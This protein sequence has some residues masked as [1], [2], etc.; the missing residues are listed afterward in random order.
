MHIVL[1]GGT[2]FVG[3]ALL[4]LL[5]EKGHTST[6]LTRNKSQHREINLI[7]GTRLEQ[8]N[9]YLPDDLC[10]HLE[11]ADA[12]INLVG[13]LNESGRNGAGFH[14]AHVQLVDEMISACEK[15]GIQ[16]I[17]HMSALNAGA[18]ESHYLESKGLAERRIARA[19]ESRDLHFTIFQPSVIFGKNDDFFNRF[20]A[21]LRVLPVMPLARPS[22]RMQPVFVGDVAA[23]FAL[24]LEDPGTH[25]KTFALCGPKTYTLK[26][27]VEFTAKT[28]NLQRKIIPLPDWLA[29]LQALVMDFVPGKP[30]SSDNYRSLKTDSTSKLNGLGYFKITPTSIETQVFQ[31]LG[32]GTHQDLLSRLRAGSRFR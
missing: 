21:L 14:R 18:G 13:I 5:A 27:L 4:P 32:R 31:Y 17:L 16:R 12:V 2:G 3:R 7:P 22:A 24:A 9:V 1:L 28:A 8:A 15:S 19:A 23:A 26:E 11:K 6:V 20:E 10:R 29:R 30:F 25:G